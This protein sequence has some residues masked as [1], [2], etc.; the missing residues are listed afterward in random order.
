M[1]ILSTDQSSNLT[2]WCLFVDGSPALTG[3]IN[4][5]GN[6]NIADRIKS[7]FLDI[8]ALMDEHK[9]DIAVVEAVQRQANEKT[10]MMLSQLQGMALA[11]A[12]ERGIPVYSPM[13]VEW[14]ST[15]GFHQGPKVKRPEL[16]AQAIAYVKEHYNLDLSEDEAEATCISTAIYQQLQQEV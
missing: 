7:M 16:K 1:R 13:P 4:H 11:A 9:P 12:Y 8:A 5:S 3:T 6:K 10:M 14:R 2:G 15:L